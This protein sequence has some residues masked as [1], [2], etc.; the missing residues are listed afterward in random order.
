MAWFL[1]CQCE[2]A[3]MELEA[4]SVI[5]TAAQPEHGAMSGPTVAACMD[6]SSIRHSRLALRERLEKAAKGRVRYKVDAA[7][8]T[9]TQVRSRQCWQ[10]GPGSLRWYFEG[11]WHAFMVLSRSPTL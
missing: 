9:P 10:A 3:S 5:L 11:L 7:E 8:M 1:V 4:G 6:S 2:L